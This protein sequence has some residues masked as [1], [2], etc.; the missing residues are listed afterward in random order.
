EAAR[1]LLAAREQVARAIGGAPSEIIFTSG[2][3]EANTLGFLGAARAARGRHLVVSAFEHPS[4]AD[5]AR[6]LAE[7]GWQVTAVAPA[8]DGVVSVEK[9]ADAL[10]PDT[11]AV[12]ILWVQNE[13]GT[14]QP[15]VEIA[16]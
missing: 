5:A 7:E 2:G 9:V 1:R 4:I 12:A 13:I 3:T 10:R 14:V 6:R 15:V 16:E 8:A 11:S